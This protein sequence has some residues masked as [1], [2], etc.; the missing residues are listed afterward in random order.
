MNLKD[1]VV[2]ITGA[3]GGIGSAIAKALANKGCKLILTGR[4]LEELQVLKQG[5]G[6]ASSLLEMDV[7]NSK[8]V[9]K[10][11]SKIEEN[12]QSP[13]VLVN[14]AG[15][16]PLTYL[17]NLHL[18][19]WLETIE[20]NVKGVLRTVHGVLPS[21]KKKREVRLLILPRLMEK[22]YTREE[23]FTVLPKPL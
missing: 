3:N 17:K 18:D 4:N 14:V 2:V 1:K 8:S 9:A 5:I 7:S 19:E 23:P 11:F 6:E 15:V 13:D 20:V 22:N 12:H 16:M 21:M 10:A